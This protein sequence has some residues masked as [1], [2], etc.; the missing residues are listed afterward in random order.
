MAWRRSG[1]K[2]LS[3]PMMVSLSEP[4]LL[5]FNLYRNSDNFIQEN[6]FENVI[7]KMAAILSRPQCD[8]GIIL[9]AVCLLMAWHQ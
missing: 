6:A 3:E 8:N 9:S 5:Q 4:K 2:P 1:A 7:S